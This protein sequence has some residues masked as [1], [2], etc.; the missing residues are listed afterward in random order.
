MKSANNDVTK[1]E[2]CILV[3]LSNIPYADS[4]SPDLSA[5]PRTVRSTVKQYDIDLFE[6]SEDIRTKCPDVQADQELDCSRMTNNA[7]SGKRVKYNDE[8]LW[9][10]QVLTHL[11]YLIFSDV[12]QL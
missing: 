1:Y 7:R 3:L 9:L 8:L 10:G 4:V 12:T 11:L 5:Y 6:G 2:K